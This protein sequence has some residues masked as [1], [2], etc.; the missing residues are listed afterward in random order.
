MKEKIFNH[1]WTLMNTDKKQQFLLGNHEL[2]NKA[3]AREWERRGIE[4][5]L[6]E[7]TENGMN[8][9]GF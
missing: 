8:T 9:K 2:R 4:Q 3:F 1:G 5:E 7:T 6:T